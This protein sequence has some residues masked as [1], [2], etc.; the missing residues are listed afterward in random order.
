MDE[1]IRN[2]ILKDKGKLYLHVH[3]FVEAYL[4]KGIKSI[5][6]KWF[7]KYKKWVTIIPRDTFKYLE[8]KIYNSKKEELVGY[9]N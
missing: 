7:I 9:S 1:T 5:Q 6:M 4:T 8:Y 3:P 2:I